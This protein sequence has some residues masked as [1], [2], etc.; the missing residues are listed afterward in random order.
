MPEFFW[1]KDADGT[2]EFAV[3]GW[4][5]TSVKYL[6]A[7]ALGKAPLSAKIN[8]RRIAK[9][10]SQYEGP[11]GWNRYL[12]MRGDARVNDWASWV[13]NSKFDSDEARAGAVNLA[14]R[15][16]RAREGRTRSAISRCT[17]CC[18]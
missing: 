9:K 3:P 4:D 8:L 1:Q 10:T 15:E 13:A 18:A 16:G 6:T 17:A 5:V 7:L 11:L 2:L 14:E 12:A